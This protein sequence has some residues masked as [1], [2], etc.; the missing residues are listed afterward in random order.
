MQNGC[1]T[2]TLSWIDR[3]NWKVLPRTVVRNRTSFHEN[4]LKTYRL[5]LF[6]D[7]PTNT[8]TDTSDYTT[9]LAKVIR[10]TPVE[11]V[12]G[13]QNLSFYFL[14]NS[15]PEMHNFEGVSGWHV[16]VVLVSL[17]Y[18]WLYKWR[19]AG[20]SSIEFMFLRLIVAKSC[21]DQPCVKI[22]VSSCRCMKSFSLKKS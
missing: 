8:R 2:G 6:A 22:A 13:L 14:Y 10:L 21:Y 19:S 1:H 18:T 4:R 7:R 20:A 16:V 5:I 3:K 17:G 12:L 11:A 9:S 15:F